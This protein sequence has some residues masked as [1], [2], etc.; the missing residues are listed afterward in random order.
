MPTLKQFKSVKLANQAVMKLITIGT[1][2]TFMLLQNVIQSSESNVSLTVG[3]IVLPGNR[4]HICSAETTAAIADLRSE[5][6]N[7]ISDIDESRSRVCECGY[8]G[9]GW[10]RVVSLN[11]TDTDQNCPGEWQIRSSPRRTCRRRVNVRGCSVAAFSTNGLRYSEVCGRIIGYQYGTTDA[12]YAP[13][14]SKVTPDQASSS[15]TI[16]DG[17]VF[18]SHGNPPGRQHIW[19]L[20]SGYSQQSI[21][22]RGCPC[23]IGNN[24]DVD[25]I[26]RDVLW[27]GQ[28]YF[29]DSATVAPSVAH[30]FYQDNPLWDGVGCNESVTT[31]CQFNNP[32][33]FCK[34]LPQPTSDDVELRLCADQSDEETPI[35]FIEIYVR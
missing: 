17:G 18:I 11:M 6:K 12:L 33:W 5:I 22:V 10:R 9:A 34:Q 3:A 20:I 1:L 15:V 25:R 21:D 28:D 2:T 35:E 8:A 19:S 31:C 16:Y 27:L 24:F 7:L 13:V 14:V 29:C 26:S 4:E 23:N 30:Q 32:P